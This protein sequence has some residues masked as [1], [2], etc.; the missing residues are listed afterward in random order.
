MID[1]SDKV[2]SVVPRIQI[3]FYFIYS[4]VFFSYFKYFFHISFYK[5]IFIINI[6]NNIP[7]IIVTPVIILIIQS[8]RD[9]PVVAGLWGGVAKEVR[10]LLGGNPL[11][12]YL[13]SYFSQNDKN[14]T[15]NN[16]QYDIIKSV[17]N[18]KLIE[19]NTTI[20]DVDE[21]KKIINTENF[22]KEV[23]WNNF[24][25]NFMCHDSVSCDKWRPISTSDFKMASFSSKSITDILGLKFNRFQIPSDPQWP[26][27]VKKK[28]AKNT[29]CTFNSP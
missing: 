3:N 16:S 15:L 18:I 2:K 8:D 7:I 14:R 5:L 22:L 13:S 4:F 6:I 23:L 29:K 19:E 27:E 10:A 17:D 12:Y 25:Q 1:I 11:Q 21:G 24:R 20:D 26:Q 9:K 28:F